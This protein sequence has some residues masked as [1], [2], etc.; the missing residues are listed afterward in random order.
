MFLWFETLQTVS[1]TLKL[2]GYDEMSG[3]SNTVF[4]SLFKWRWIKVEAEMLPGTSR[5]SRFLRS[6]AADLRWPGRCFRLL[7]APSAWAVGIQTEKKIIKKPSTGLFLGTK[8]KLCIDVLVA[9]R[10]CRWIVLWTKSVLNHIGD[11]NGAKVLLQD[12]YKFLDETIKTFKFKNNSSVINLYDYKPWMK[13]WRNPTENLI[14][15]AHQN[16]QPPSK[17]VMKR[18]KVCKP[19][20]LSIFRLASGSLRQRMLCHW[21][22]TC[23]FYTDHPGQ[24]S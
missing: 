16:T 19:M 10:F 23:F 8:I 22:Q 12:P 17:T 14:V 2:N 21:I 18:L 1:L 11:T 7:S 5:L 15:L 13:N 6:V 20:M 24:F 4:S 9:L 3:S